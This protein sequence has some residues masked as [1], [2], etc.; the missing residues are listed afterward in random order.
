MAKLFLNTAARRRSSDGSISPGRSLVINDFG[1]ISY[2]NGSGFQTCPAQWLRHRHRRRAGDLR[3]AL[4]LP[5]GDRIATG[6]DHRKWQHYQLQGSTW[7]KTTKVPPVPH[8]GL[9]REGAPGVINAAGSHFYWNA[10]SYRVLT[11]SVPRVHLPDG[12][13]SA[14]RSSAMWETYGLLDA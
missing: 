11:P 12:P 5:L 9:H 6:S 14:G 4:W 10:S 3:A 1:E 13:A 7:V 2:W 8:R